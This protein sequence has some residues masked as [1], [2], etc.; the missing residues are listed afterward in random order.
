MALMLAPH[1]TAAGASWA[2]CLRTT[3][4]ESTARYA[5]AGPDQLLCL[6]AVAETAECAGGDRVSIISAIKL[7]V[8]AYREGRTKL[9]DAKTRTKGTGRITPWRSSGSRRT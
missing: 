9:F 4:Q 1:G 7:G 3:A 8:Y 2:Q 5:D 6:R